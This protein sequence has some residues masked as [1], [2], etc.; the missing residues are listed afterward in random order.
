MLRKAKQAVA[1]AS[2]EDP[3]MQQSNAEIKKVG[4][5]LTALKKQ[6]AGVDAEIADLKKSGA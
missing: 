3:R 6:I 1:V 2:H 4:K 5:S